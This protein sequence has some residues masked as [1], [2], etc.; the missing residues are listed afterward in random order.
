MQWRERIG[1]A[2]W[3]VALGIGL[4]RGEALGLKWSDVDLNRLT[5]RRS[6]Q[7]VDGG[8]PLWSGAVAMVLT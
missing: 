4:R 8:R 7:R 5:V 3:A 6:L 2:L 1:L